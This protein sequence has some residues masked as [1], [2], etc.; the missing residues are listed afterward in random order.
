ML[1][2]QDKQNKTN[3]HWGTSLSVQNGLSHDFSNTANGGRIG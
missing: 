1:P 3:I 2:V